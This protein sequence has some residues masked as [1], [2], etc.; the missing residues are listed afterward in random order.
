M[1]EPEFLRLSSIAVTLLSFI[2]GAIFGSFLNVIIVR[3]PKKLEYQW[4]R[5]CL[6]YLQLCNTHLPEEKIG[7]AYPRSHCPNCKIAL[8]WWQNIPLVSFFLLRGRCGACQREISVRY[9]IIELISALVTVLSIAKFGP[10]STM[11]YALI[12][13]YSLLVLGA[14]DADCKL[15]PDIITVPLLWLG[16]FVN[17]QGHFTN[18]HSAVLGGMLGYLFLWTVF[19]LFKV[20]TGKDGMG[21]GDFK[22]LA[23]IGAWLGWELLPITLFLSSMTALI[24]GLVTFSLKL[25]KKDDP[26]PFGA[27]I[28]AAGWVL[29]YTES[30]DIFF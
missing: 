4:K 22:L 5:E 29:L 11:V 7:I 2:F 15:L 17:S 21:Y 9:P 19:Q 27:F 6:D 13:S 24:A 30:Y 14:I 20:V 8:A 28:A 12:F 16:L 10:T 26:I 25:M 18:L 3:L 1:M 23:A